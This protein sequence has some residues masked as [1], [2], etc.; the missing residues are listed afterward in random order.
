M[1]AQ[2]RKD[3]DAYGGWTGLKTAAGGFFRVERTGDRWW[4]VT[5]DGH[6]F[7]SVGMNHLDLAALKYP[8]NIHIF[9]GRYG[10]S[11]EVYIR[12]GIARPLLEWG[13]NT[14]GWTQECVGGKWM[15]PKRLLRHSP[16]WTHE[17]FQLAGMPYIYNLPFSEIETFNINPYYP[18]VFD[19]DFSDWADYQARSVCVDMAEE[20]L[21]MGY[22]DLPVPDITRDRP[23]AWAEG[24]DLKKEAD[25]NRLKEIV[26]RY[27]E[28]T[29]GAI[30]RYDP[31]HL[32][33]GPR[34]NQDIPGWVIEIAGEFVD[35]LLCNW[36][37]TAESA[38]TDLAEWDRLANRP[39]LISDM[40]FRAPTS[41]LDVPEDTP[42]YAPDQKARGQAYR[43][44][45][46]SVLAH[47]Y[48][49]GIHWCAFL[50]NRTR[51]SGIK[52]YLDEPYR[53]CVDTVTK[54]NLREL[55]TT[56][57]DITSKK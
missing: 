56:A 20:P 4:F 49:L 12:E 28:V 23:G 47:P 8:D 48:I 31:N 22:A 36:F 41:I 9:K 16:E 50:E 34:F 7:I 14:I 19:H 25:L 35:V 5:P 42:A 3:R 30:R 51:K 43:R 1:T 38:A 57:R 40:A 39:V 26:R 53:D 18:D 54:F 45:A 6:G 15:D 46:R 17:Q 21:L 24:L 13:F 32:I 10:G 2:T 29:T 27:F 52:T 37:V 11:N 33:F 44:H 55:Y